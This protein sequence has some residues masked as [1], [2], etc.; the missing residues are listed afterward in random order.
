MLYLWR[1]KQA[2]NWKQKIEWKKGESLSPAKWSE[3][4]CWCE[5]GVVKEDVRPQNDS[6]MSLLSFPS[7]ERQ[8]ESTD[9]SKNV[10]GLKQIYE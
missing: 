2:E 4:R 9:S 7:W 6:K 10:K 5:D 1:T 8:A 3:E